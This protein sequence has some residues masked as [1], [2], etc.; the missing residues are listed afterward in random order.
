ML[1]HR[2]APNAFSLVEMVFATAL[3]A[4]TLAPALAVMR[5]AMSTSREATRRLL[6]ANYVVQTLE[7]LQVTTMQNWATGTATGNF[8]ADGY[9][10]IRY[11]ATRSDAP[12]SGGLPNQLMHIQ[13]TVFDDANGNAALDS[14]ELA[15]RFRTK[16][17]KLS[18]YQS[19]AN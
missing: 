14:T 1:R 13:V 10:T 15:V 6:L 16:V 7:T 2:H 8:S 3:V 11:T 4:G 5:N 17:A 18:S 9:S 19:V 12:A